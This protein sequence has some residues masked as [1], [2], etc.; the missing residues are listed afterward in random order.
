MAGKDLGA[1]ARRY[2]R[3]FEK[4]DRA[5]V[6]DNLAD[7]FTFTSPYDDRIGR[8]EYFERCWPNS[9]RLRKFTFAAVMARGD[10]V[11]VLYDCETTDGSSF[12][13]AEYM[14]FEDGKL[15]SVE[16][17]FG[18]PPTGIEKDDYP[19]FVDVG[20]QAWDQ[21]LHSM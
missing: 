8:D 3:A 1:L 19:A 7:G 4:R 6:E 9:E 5:F 21:R 16:V 12:R 15:K 20:K 18:D 11:F 10:N 14:T 17:Y 13:N 2:Y